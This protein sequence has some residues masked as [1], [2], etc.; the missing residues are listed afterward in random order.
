MPRTALLLFFLLFQFALA[1]QS[2]LDEVRETGILRIGTTGD[3]KPFTFFKDGEYR[4]F[5]PD[6]ARMIAG[7]LGVDV[8]MV[9]S[10]WTGLVGDLEGQRFHLAVGGVTRTLKRQTR[11]AFTD[12]VYLI[13]KCPLVRSGEAGKYDS[14]TKIDR[15][16]VTVAVNPGGTNEAYVR[17]HLKRARILV[18]TDNLKIPELV[19]GGKADVML[20]DNVEARLAGRRDPRLEAVSPDH[21]WTSESLGLMTRRDDQAFVNWLNLFLYQ[22]EADGRLQRLREKW[23][24]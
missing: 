10:D 16:D 4:G 2:I 1:Q 23:G 3:Y 11:A 21:P 9:R 14:L 19:A 12:P 13:G 5:G 22:A 20:T 7:E 6:L 8:K 17:K 24:I 15:P 18:E